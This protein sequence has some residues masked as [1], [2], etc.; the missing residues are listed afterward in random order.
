MEWISEEEEENDTQEPQAATGAAA[1][2]RLSAATILRRAQALR[3]SDEEMF[4][5]L[6]AVLS[7]TPGMAEADVFAFL[8]R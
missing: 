5:T 6:Q 1:A 4:A 8:A 2:P 7:S 3:E